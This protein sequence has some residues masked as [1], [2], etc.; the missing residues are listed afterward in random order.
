MARKFHSHWLALPDAP[1]Y[2][3]AF[4]VSMLLHSIALQY[5]TGESSQRRHPITIDASIAFMP[6]GSGGGGGLGSGG[7]S[8]DASPEQFLSAP[9]DIPPPIDAADDLPDSPVMDTITTTPSA[10]SSPKKTESEKPPH[11]RS[12]EELKRLQ[13]TLRQ[14]Y[15]EDSAGLAY[16]PG[17][18]AGGTGTGGGAGPAGGPYSGPYIPGVPGG[19]MI[20]NYTFLISRKIRSNVNRD[21]CRKGNPEI[22]F[23]IRLRRDGQLQSPPR[24]IQ[25]SGNIICDTAIERAILQSLPLPVPRDSTA[26]EALQE[27]HLLFRPNDKQFESVS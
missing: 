17:G 23:A 7:N 3:A 18:I 4:I 8:E 9:L 6:A 14:Q 13:Q 26:F 5:L 15:L 12:N 16:D 1:I 25:S 22:I 19:T 11:K 20:G 24:L 27:L 21:L 2:L 10:P